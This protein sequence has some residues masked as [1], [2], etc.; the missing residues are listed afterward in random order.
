MKL[1]C[2]FPNPVVSLGTFALATV[3]SM[4]AAAASY[5]GGGNAD[6]LSLSDMTFNGALATDCYGVV[7]GNDK[8]SAVNS[9]AW[10]NDWALLTK[11]ESPVPATFMGIEFDLDSVGG[12]W[13]SWSLVARDVNGASL[14]DLP[15]ELDVVAVLKASNRYAAYLFDDAVFDGTDGG[16]W[17]IAFQNQGGQIPKLSHMS[18]YVRIDEDGG[19]PSAIPEAQTYAMM[20]VGLGLVGFMARRRA[21]LSA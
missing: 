19:M 13:G 2:R 7:M 3:L 12:K 6:G 10:G 5:C 17:S 9:L 21:R 18:F 14:L 1:P 20:L 11:D 4:P 15:V 16:T 8:L